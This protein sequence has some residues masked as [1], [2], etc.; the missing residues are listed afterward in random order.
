MNQD[1]ERQRR[2]SVGLD[3]ILGP[4]FQWNAL[5]T[6]AATE[7][8]A[9]VTTFVT[10]A[11]ILV[12]NPGILSNAIFLNESGDLF[13]ELVIATAFSA[14]IASLVMGLYAK[15]P[16]VLAP[17]MGLNAYFTFSIVLRLGIDWRTA[18]AAVFIEGIIFIIL[19][20]TN[21]R[22]QIVKAIP[23]GLKHATAAGIGMFIAYIGLKNAN[24]IVANEVTTTTLGELSNP[25][26]LVAI[27]GLVITSAFVA[28]RMTGALLLGILATSM[29]GWIFGVAPLPEGVIALP[30]WPGDLFGQAIVGLSGIGEIGITEL[31]AILFVLLFVDLFDTVGTLAGVG[32]KAGLID[33]RGELPR[34]SQAFMADAVGTT[35]G[36]VLGTSTVTTYI[37]SASGISEGGRSGFTAVIAALFFILSIFFIPLI[38][39]IPPFATS[40][41]LIIIGVLMMS[42]VRSIDWDEPAVAISAFLTII[43]IPLSFSIAEGLAIGFLTYP[44]L[45]AFQGRAYEV[46][47][48]VWIIAAIFALRFLLMGLHIGG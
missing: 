30:Q 2:T 33:R 24:L 40:P 20:V 16:F 11:Y 15:Y 35:V 26:T 19:T 7:I 37:E 45:K 10:M 3:D 13:G 39:G 18:L 4:F 42:S 27:A 34:S 14:A 25:T 17:G 47:P 31:L 23:D 12:V 5:R 21:V 22:S 48:A 43:L 36:A 44:L 38:S 9:G 1:P 46:S 8:L 41:A 6:N 28:R 32:M 29:L